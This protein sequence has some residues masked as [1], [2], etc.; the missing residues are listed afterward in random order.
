MHTAELDSVWCTLRTELDATVGCI[1]RSLTWY[2][3]HCVQNLTPRWGAYPGAWLGMMHTACR[4]RLH[5]G[6][7]TA[8]FFWKKITYYKTVKFFYLAQVKNVQNLSSININ[9]ILFE[10]WNVTQFQGLKFFHFFQKKLHFLQL[11]FHL[12]PLHFCLTSIMSEK[13]KYRHKINKVIDTATLKFSW[14]LSEHLR[15]ISQKW[16]IVFSKNMFIPAL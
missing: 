13:F 16:K 4:T 2:D 6:V 11:S 7:H 10:N 1:L 15:N 8:E 14:N 12:R 3:A 9:L 5:G